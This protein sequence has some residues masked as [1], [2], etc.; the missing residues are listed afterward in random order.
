MKRIFLIIQF[1]EKYALINYFKSILPF[2][3]AI[4]DG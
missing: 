1:C 3:N 4:S 2:D